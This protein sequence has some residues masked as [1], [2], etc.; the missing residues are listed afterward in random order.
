VDRVVESLEANG[1]RFSSLILG[2]VATEAFRMRRGEG[3]DLQE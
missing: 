2:V 1:H 3:G